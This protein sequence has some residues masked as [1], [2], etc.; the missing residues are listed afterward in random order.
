LVVPGRR[1]VESAATSRFALAWYVSVQTFAAAVFIVTSGGHYADRVSSWDGGFYLSIAESGRYGV[2]GGEG[3][4]SYYPA[5]PFLVRALAAVTGLPVL[6]TA[7]AVSF[8]AGAFAVVVLYRSV[9]VTLGE[10]AARA[11]TALTCTWMA[12]PVL[13]MTYTDGLGLLL[14]CL[15]LDG[16]ARRRYLALLVVLPLLA[17]TRGV[18]P[19]VVAVALIQA[20]VLRRSGGPW[21][22]AVGLG[23]Y[24]AVLSLLWPVL[25]GLMTG[26]PRHYFVVADMW[27]AN[28]VAR[29]WFA[30]FVGWGPIGWCVVV[31]MIGLL[32]WAAWR[33]MPERSPVELRTWA[34]AYPLFLLLVTYPSGSLV[35][36]LLLSFP[37][38]LLLVPRSPGS[39]W[40]WPPVALALGAGLVA[41]VFWIGSFAGSTGGPVP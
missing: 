40:S 6:A 28:A 32:V 27:S 9:G 16:L 15:A 4:W 25:V 2:L 38:A 30:M 3:E 14:T 8:T 17:L 29:S 12:A 23:A 19:A 5:Y 34:V 37:L 36:Y 1:L 11:V 10:P 33:G 35:R 21:A 20:I 41:Q 24:A 31:L 39:R 7:V 22:T 26:D 18:L 13:Q